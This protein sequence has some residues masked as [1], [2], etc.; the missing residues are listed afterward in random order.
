[1]NPTRLVSRSSA[2]LRLPRRG[3]L[4]EARL[5]KLSLASDSRDLCI[6]HGA[7]RR[8]S[9]AVDVVHP[10]SLSKPIPLPCTHISRTSSEMQLTEDMALAEFREMCMFHRLVVGMKERQQALEQNMTSCHDIYRKDF[11][12][13]FHR[14]VRRLSSANRFPTTTN[15]CNEEWESP[16]FAEEP[17]RSA[18]LVD[19]LQRATEIADFPTEKSKRRQQLRRRSSVVSAEGIF[20]LD[21]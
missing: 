19:V 14:H 18:Y 1:M 9:I 13:G 16:E 8:K 15:T 11:S 2:G 4:Q 3:S 10:K 12:Q 21:L 20:I 6:Q 17:S 5:P 7:S